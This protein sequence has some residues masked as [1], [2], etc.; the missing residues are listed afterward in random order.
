MTEG[1]AVD[2]ATTGHAPG[3]P[4]LT[5][6]VRGI[7]LASL[8]A[9]VGHE[10]PTA[11]LPGLLGAI[12]AAPAAALGLVE[13]IADALSGITRFIGGALADDP[14]RRRSIAVG[15]YTATAILSALIGLATAVWQVALLRAGAWAAR[16][17]RVPSRNALLADAVDRAAFGRAYGFERAMDNLGAVIG[18]VLALVLVSAIG[19]RAAILLGVV[20]GLAAA[21]AIVYA[22]R[23]LEQPKERHTAPVRL[24]VRPL[25]KGALGRTLAAVALFEAGNMAA[26]LLILR[27]TDL[28]TPARGADAA[29][30]TAIALYTGYN[31]VAT[32]G[33]YP[34]GRL[35]DRFGARRVLGVGIA[36]FGVAY[37]AFALVGADVL[38][39][40]L[41]FA[42][43]GLA[44]GAVETA[45]SAAVATMAPEANRG[46]AFG[47]LA[48][49]QSLGDLV[50]SGMVGVIWAI[51][52]APLAFLLAGILMAASVVTL[53]LGRVAGTPERAPAT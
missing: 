22:V 21:A 27:A 8:L 30:T 33:S 3:R 17:L 53:V 19:L 18:P 7:G 47:L 36:T 9:D 26:T 29:A 11:L 52:G 42:L 37:L 23:H 24:V 51:A 48:G 14:R 20:P 45:Q 35:A 10:I 43:A 15:G 39:L 4:W 6:G 13:G 12:T 50:A 41:A 31:L 44:I 28:L 38:L 49:I 2:E 25:L 16:G 40:G 34:A 46:S 32:I 1:T 5:P